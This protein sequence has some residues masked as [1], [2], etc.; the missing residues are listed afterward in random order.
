[1]PLT[2]STICRGA[3]RDGPA[4]PG[5]VGARD[6]FAPTVP[7]RTRSMGNA[8]AAGGTHWEDRKGADGRDGRQFSP[9]PLLHRDRIN[10]RT[11]LQLLPR[12]L[13]A[14]SVNTGASICLKTL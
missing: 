7:M 4:Q 2:I 5:R 14:I 8:G 12:S 1:M 13:F 6:G 3:H 9:L 10:P 11:A